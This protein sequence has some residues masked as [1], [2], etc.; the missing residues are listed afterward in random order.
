MKRRDFAGPY[1]D[2]GAVPFDGSWPLRSN[3]AT[4]QTRR[5]QPSSRPC[6]SGSVHWA[7]DLRLTPNGRFLYAAERTS[8]TLAHFRVDPASGK[9]TYL[10]STP[11][12]KQP[13]GFNID[14]TGRFVVVSGEQSDTI[15][16]YA[17]DAETGALKPI[18][19]YPTG[20]GANWVEI[21]AFD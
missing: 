2:V 16:S 10:G 20:K 15:S 14:P 19:R 9:L 5:F 7:S 3:I 1:D 12:E 13:R 18:G 4:S 8:S 21:V 17:I 6:R 11:T